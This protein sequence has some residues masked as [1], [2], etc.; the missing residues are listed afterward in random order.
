MRT[1]NI[2]N[3]RR[4]TYVHSDGY[5]DERVRKSI[6]AFLSF[7]LYFLLRCYELY[8]R[9]RGN[10][11]HGSRSFAGRNFFPAT[12]QKIALARRSKRVARAVRSSYIRPYVHEWRA[13]RA[14]IRAC[15]YPFSPCRRFMEEYVRKYLRSAFREMYG[16][17]LYRGVC[18]SV[19]ARK[20]RDLRE[21]LFRPPSQREIRRHAA[22]VVL[23]AY[24]SLFTLFSW[25]N[26]FDTNYVFWE[27]S[28]G[29]PRARLRCQSVNIKIITRRI[30][31][32]LK[33]FHRGA[34]CFYS[35]IIDIS[36]RY[37]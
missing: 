27:P 37:R 19:R 11:Q 3:S 22:A 21:T 14:L 20:Q 1:V 16:D 26:N 12:F 36:W 30:Y 8:T 5:G 24:A 34:T 35:N 31:N 18:A 9:K 2:R 29:T 6:R 33:I 28:Q 13:R 32:M 7:S 23:R 10:A 17:S 15:D 25:W 4:C